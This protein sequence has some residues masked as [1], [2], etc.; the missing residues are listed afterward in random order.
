MEHLTDTTM[1]KH[2]Q[3][4]DGWS[5]DE[6]SDDEM[7]CAFARWDASTWADLPHCVPP[8]DRKVARSDAVACG[9]REAHKHGVASEIRLLLATYKPQL[10]GSKHPTQPTIMSWLLGLTACSFD[11]GLANQAFELLSLSLAKADSVDS[12]G[13]RWPKLSLL[14]E[15]INLYGTTSPLPTQTAEL[16]AQRYRSES[17]STSGAAMTAAGAAAANPPPAL[18]PARK[19]RKRE[20]E[21]PG[22][23]DIVKVAFNGQGGGKEQYFDGEVKQTAAEGTIPTGTTVYNCKGSPYA[24]ARMLPK[25]GMR[26]VCVCVLVTRVPAG[27]VRA[28]SLSTFRRMRNTGGWMQSSKRTLRLNEERQR[29]RVN[30]SC[31]HTPRQGSRM[32]LRKAKTQVVPPAKTKGSHALRLK[33]NRCFRWPTCGSCSCWQRRLFAD[34]VTQ[35]P[36][37]PPR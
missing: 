33:V 31:I 21:V 28:I 15:Y 1:A 9:F 13:V 6:D 14:A 12:G 4:V 37:A 22:V 29:S 2:R 8:I 25:I 35:L 34:P 10:S 36:S 3:L 5:D 27:S 30:R 18:S 19:R 11:E 26:S 24:C 23:G 20:I 32:G 17:R 16:R 7:P